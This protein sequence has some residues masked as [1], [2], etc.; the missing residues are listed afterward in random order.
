MRLG[1]KGQKALSIAKKGVVIAGAVGA[2]AGLGHKAENKYEGVKAEV[3]SEIDKKKDEAQAAGVVAG[4][5]ANIGVA[6]VKDAAANPFKAKKGLEKSKKMAVGVAA[7]G[8]VD[9]QGA[10]AQAKFAA[11]PKVADPN[12]PTGKIINRAGSDPQGADTRERELNKKQKAKAAAKAK[13]AKAAA[14]FKAGGK[15]GKQEGSFKEQKK[16]K[17]KK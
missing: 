1:V 14:P 2:I 6:A 9:L 17:K 4:A 3:E 16:K 8:K 7:A 10:A 13:K 12:A 11:A 15:F 5:V